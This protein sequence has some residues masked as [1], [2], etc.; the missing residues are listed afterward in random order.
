MMKKALCTLALLGAAA[1]SQAGVLVSQNF[2]NVAALGAGWVM[3]N[4]STPAGST[5][6]GQGSPEV[7]TAH[8]G[9]ENSYISANYNNA[10]PGGMIDNW[11]ITP[12]FSTALG[13]TI[14]FWMRADKAEDYFDMVSF[15]LSDGSSN[16]ID[17]N[18]DPSFVVN[19]DGWAKYTISIANQAPGSTARFAINYNGLADEANYIGIDTLQIAEVPEPASLLLLGT[20]LAGLIASRRRRQRAA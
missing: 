16:T 20:G 5:G 14:T 3:T 13:A 19:T 4:N 18:L 17:F 12:V 6:W 9:A 8:Q 7:F 11:L 10:A 2:N 15:G 1:T